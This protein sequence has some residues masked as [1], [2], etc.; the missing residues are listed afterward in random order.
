MILAFVSRIPS[1]CSFSGREAS[2]ATHRKRNILRLILSP[3]SALKNIV[4]RHGATFYGARGLLDLPRLCGAGGGRKGVRRR[5]GNPARILG[6]GRR[7][8]GAVSR[9]VLRASVYHGAEE[10]RAEE[11]RSRFKERRGLQ[12]KRAIRT[13]RRV[14]KSADAP[15]SGPLLRTPLAA[16]VRP[17]PARLSI[18]ASAVWGE[19]SIGAPA[20]RTDYLS[21]SR[22]A[23]LDRNPGSVPPL[24]G[25]P[26]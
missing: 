24:R 25:C 5:A 9:R 19:R 26:G 11:G 6:R 7:K 17:P 4:S 18:R 13:G 16:H 12:D 8:P 23:S 15:R 3:P 14:P 22:G 20:V 1:T 21:C 10:S 2:I